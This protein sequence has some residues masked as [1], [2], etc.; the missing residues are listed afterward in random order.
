MKKNATSTNDMYQ[1][2][3]SMYKS[4]HPS[5]GI[6]D[7]SMLKLFRT[8]LRTKRVFGILTQVR[9]GTTRFSRSLVPIVSKGEEVAPSRPR[10]YES[11]VLIF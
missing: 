2:T 8:S 1:E 10:V 6:V 5:A 9:M 11:K 4:N 7:A 3:F